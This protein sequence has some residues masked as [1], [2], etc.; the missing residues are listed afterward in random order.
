MKTI[1]NFLEWIWGF[2]LVYVIYKIFRPPQ[3]LVD[4]QTKQQ[5]VSRLLN[6]QESSVN[7]NEIKNSINAMS[8]DELANL[9]KRLHR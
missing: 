6:K 5:E 9:S 1:S 3:T 4:R 8:D 2:I 7:E